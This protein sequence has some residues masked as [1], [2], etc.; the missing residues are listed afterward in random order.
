LTATRLG[1]L[2]QHQLHNGLTVGLLRCD[3][4]PIVSTV[5]WYRVGTADEQEAQR[6]IAH[7]LEHMMFKG[8]ESFGPGEVD[9]LTQALGGS[10]NAFTS[11]DAT[12]YY[13]QFASD[14]WRRALEI[15]ADRMRGLLLEATEVEHERNVIYEEIAMYESD[16]WDALEMRVQA[17][18]FGEHPYGRPVLGTRESLAGVGPAELAA[19]QSRFYCPANAVLLVAGDI[20]AEALDEVEATFGALP[21]GE[22]ARRGGRRTDRAAR[23]SRLE[24]RHGEVARLR[25]SR[26]APAWGDAEHPALRLLLQ[27]LTEGKSSRLHRCLVEEE[28]LCSWVAGDLHSL[29]EGASLGFALEV[30]PS[31]E[32]ARV[33]ARLSELLEEV[34]REG[35]EAAEVVRARR[36]F[37]ADWVFA[38]ERVHQRALTLASAIAH[39]DADFAFG[40]L[41]SLLATPD[42]CLEALARQYLLPEE[43]VW[44]WS[45]S[46]AEVA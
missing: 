46:E 5:L 44:A 20:G 35:L 4:A 38:H 22:A 28:Q 18:V 12:A 39:L 9:R 29:L 8:S 37:E 15:E 23:P 13:F 45:L 6:G 32:P 42:D 10:N 43:G 27:A 41:D 24:R 11:H 7:F 19:F 25:W 34:A 36:T 30:A 21:P 16:P 26:P 14:C 2:S 31:V 33:E 3:H 17:S 40:Y 1:E